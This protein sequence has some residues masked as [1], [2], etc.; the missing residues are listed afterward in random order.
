[1][2]R[3]GA[4][5]FELAGNG[6]TQQK[7]GCSF[8]RE[9]KKEHVMMRGLFHM[10]HT[11]RLYY[12][13]IKGLYIYNKPWKGS[14]LDNR[15]FMETKGP[16]FFLCLSSFLGFMKVHMDKGWSADPAAKPEALVALV[17]WTMSFFAGVNKCHPFW[18]D[19][20]M[21]G[22]DNFDGCSSKE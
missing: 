18:G 6:L 8:D 5:S 15:Y 20:K 3:A 22:Y 13:V 12:P 4:K 2:W 16:R 9:E 1:M 11:T 21:P 17:G 7:P 10:I 14:L 19:Q